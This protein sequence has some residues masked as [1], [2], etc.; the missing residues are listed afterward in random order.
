MTQK[1]ES[2][3][4]EINSVQIMKTEIFC[5]HNETVNVFLEVVHMLKK[6]DSMSILCNFLIFC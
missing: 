4:P 2:D 1:A 3:W 5:P 6:T